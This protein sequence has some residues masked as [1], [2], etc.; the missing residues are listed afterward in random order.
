MIDIHVDKAIDLLSQP[1]YLDEMGELYDTAIFNDYN[2]EYGATKITI[3]LDD[4]VLKTS[5]E[6]HMINHYVNNEVVR[7][8]KKDFGKDWS[9]AALVE[10]KLYLKAIDYGVD[11]FFAKVEQINDKVFKQEK[12]DFCF[13]SFDEIIEEIREDNRKFL[14]IHSFYELCEQVELLDKLSD[15]FGPKPA[16]YL[17]RL[18]DEESLVRLMNFLA[19]Y[20]INDLHDGNVGVTEEGDFKIF[21]FSGFGSC[22]GRLINLE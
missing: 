22:A 2:V 19:K 18:Y 21:D 6:G 1:V 3:I 17:F 5:I 16:L 4:F 15:Y 10:Y 7:S 12:V 8:V 11:D 20:D 14:G 9:D 13:D